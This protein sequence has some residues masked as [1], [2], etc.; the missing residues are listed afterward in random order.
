M[1]RI[2]REEVNQQQIRLVLADQISRGGRP[3]L[4]PEENIRFGEVLEIGR[5]EHTFADH[6]LLQRTVRGRPLIKIPGNARRFIDGNPVHLRGREARLMRRVIHRWHV[7]HLLLIEHRFDFHRRPAAG[8]DNGSVREQSGLVGTNARHHRG[9]IGPGDGR[10]DACHPRGSAVF[11]E[12]PQ[13]GHGEFRIVQREGGKA[14]EADHD[15]HALSCWRLREGRDQQTE[16]G[17]E[18]DQGFHLTPEYR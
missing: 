6:L 2:E 4:I 5:R 17:G 18:P 1:H 12:L 13:R 3:G 11:D 15:D 7:H 10:I 16:A 14:V 8:A 9:V